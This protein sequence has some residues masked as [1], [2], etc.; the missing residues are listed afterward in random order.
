[1]QWENLTAPEFAAAV[2][3]TG[4]CVLGMGIC[5]R[6][7][8]HL[9]IG[10]DFLVIH[11]IVS[12]AAE[13]EPAVVFP[14]WYFGQIYEAQCYPG[15]VSAGPELLFPLIEGVLDE[16]GR[17]GFRKILIVSGHGGN[18]F[19]I[20]FI[21]QLALNRPKPYS[22]YIAE[23]L[24]AERQKQ[25]D[26]VLETDVHMHACECETSMS[27]ALHPELVK[28]DALPKGPGVAGKRLAHLEG[29]FTGVSWYADFPEHYAGDARAASVE[30]GRKLLALRV[31]SV[32]EQ[33]AM[34]KADQ[35]VPALQKEFFDRVRR[36]AEG[37]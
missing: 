25:W 22:L 2:R 26:A 1:M 9:P 12:L 4:V 19:L 27:L 21:G 18:R 34:V 8:E 30:K 31:D 24:N 15:A 36:Q 23:R 35:M 10:T 32:A 28:M 14:P 17:N 33:I 6:H 16:I 20:P 13:K 29:M 11:R 37:K 3:E 7:G 5:E